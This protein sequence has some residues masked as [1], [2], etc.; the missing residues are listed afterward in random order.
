ML[1]SLF[2]CSITLINLDLDM[3]TAIEASNPWIQP[4][5]SS[6]LSP[7]GENFSLSFGLGRQERLDLVPNFYSYAIKATLMPIRRV[8]HELVMNY[9]QYIHP[10]FP[11]V[12]EHYFTKIYRKYRGQEQYMDP[13]DF[14]IYQ[15]ITAAGFGVSTTSNS[16]HR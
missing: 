8:Q 13:E 15:A 3:T 9:F 1:I 7:H 4:I 16:A 10:M 5:A 6:N 14:M 2:A 11:V 12:D